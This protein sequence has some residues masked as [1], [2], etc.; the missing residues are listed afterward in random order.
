MRLLW[1][2][3]AAY[4]ASQLM[5]TCP[6]KSAVLDVGSGMPVF[7][8]RLRLRHAVPRVE[9]LDVLGPEMLRELRELDPEAVHHN[10]LLKDFAAGEARYDVVTAYHSLEHSY[11]P[12]Q[13]LRVL[14][15]MLSPGGTLVLGVP[16]F[17]HA[18]LRVFGAPHTSFHVPYHLHFFSIPTL[19][20]LLNE[21]GFTVRRVETEWFFSS[22]NSVTSLLTRLGMRELSRPRLGLTL[23]FLLTWPMA[24]IVEKVCPLGGC[25]LIMARKPD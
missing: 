13:F 7:A 19:R 1:R 5:R 20:T 22:V 6:G 4:R 9:S 23:L 10:V 25:V 24:A 11:D 18:G 21:A 14:N 12:K 17:D 15:A 3:Q 16:H 8:R 2:L